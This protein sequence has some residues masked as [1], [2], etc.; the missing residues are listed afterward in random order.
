MLDAAKEKESSGKK[1]MMTI[2]IHLQG[3]GGWIR[4]RD[5]LKIAKSL[6]IDATCAPSNN[7]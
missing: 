5:A 4:R 2:P 1:G 3:G 6:M 7:Y